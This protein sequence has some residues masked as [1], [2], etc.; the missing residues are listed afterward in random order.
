VDQLRVE[1]ERLLDLS[2]VARERRGARYA[3]AEL[4]RAVARRLTGSGT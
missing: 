2:R 1:R 3:V 4:R